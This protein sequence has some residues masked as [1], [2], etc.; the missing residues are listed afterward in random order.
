MPLF[1]AAFSFGTILGALSGWVAE[2]ASVGLVP[3]IAGVAALATISAIVAL[4]WFLP[5]PAETDV[6]TA[7]AAAGE[8]PQVPAPGLPLAAASASSTP[9]ASP[10]PSSSA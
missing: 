6:T 2:Q 5:E 3:H 7:M 9:G 10:A 4:R 8:E 1:H